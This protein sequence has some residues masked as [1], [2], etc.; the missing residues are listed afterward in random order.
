[1]DRFASS[2]VFAAATNLGDALG[3]PEDG[4]CSGVVVA[5]LRD[6]ARS[7]ASFAGI[8][9]PPDGLRFVAAPDGRLGVRLSEALSAQH[10]AVLIEA[11]SDGYTVEVVDSHSAHFA[12]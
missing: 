10:A 11:M 7:I 9:L 4:M 1:M 6:R 8:D 2:D 3:L 5:H 12:G